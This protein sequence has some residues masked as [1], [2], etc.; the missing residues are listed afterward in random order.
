MV[1]YNEGKR[2]EELGGLINPGRMI[3]DSAIA[4]HG[5]TTERA[6]AEGRDPEDAIAEI[7]EALLTASKDGVA[8]VG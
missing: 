4:V 5:I 1:Y 6:K 8:V 7:A 2:T 3:P